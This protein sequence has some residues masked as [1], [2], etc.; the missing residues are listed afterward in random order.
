MP[1]LAGRFLLLLFWGSVCFFC[2]VLFITTALYFSFRTDINFLLAKQDFIHNNMWMAAFYV[3][4]TG[5]ML[6]IATG[7]A[8]FSNWLHSRYLK[9]H[10]MA[11][12]V[13]VFAILV[14]AGPSG[15]Y[16][17]IFANGGPWASAGFLILSIL[18]IVSTYM[19][20]AKVLNKDIPAHRAWMVRSFA[21]TLGAVTL[22]LWVPVLS[23][24]FNVEHDTT[25]ILTAWLNW[26][27]NLLIAEVVIRYMLK[28]MGAK[29][30]TQ[31]TNTIPLNPLKGT[32]HKSTY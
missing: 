27:P 15:F 9:V 13:Y 21:F 32:L 12:R 3:H 4:I 28:P 29:N 25:V 31:S 11:G 8:Q 18:W 5:G 23:L 20:L 19:G 6:A 7:P 22:R 2:S 1:A 10:R 17:A 26:I 14:L 30:K 16:M 24:V